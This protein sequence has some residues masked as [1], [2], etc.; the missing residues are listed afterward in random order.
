[1][2]SNLQLFS[3]ATTYLFVL[4]Q[5]NGIRNKKQTKATTESVQTPGNISILD[6]QFEICNYH[7]KG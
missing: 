7:I 1:M 2:Y 4:V 6:E 5:F 3:L